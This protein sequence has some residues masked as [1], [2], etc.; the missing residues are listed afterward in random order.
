R[1]Q[2]G[3]ALGDDARGGRSRRGSFRAHPS[4]QP[5][6]PRGGVPAD[7]RRVVGLM[8]VLRLGLL[9]TASINRMILAGASSSDRVEVFAVASRDEARAEAYA[10]EHGI[11]RSH[12]S[13]EALLADPE[14]D[15]VYVSL[16]NGLHHEWSMHA[17]T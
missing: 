6:D 5:P 4:A 14:V 11:P 17:L 8:A 12:G 16:P 1:P 10:A 9:S 3:R 13:Y 15:A 7:E 2:P